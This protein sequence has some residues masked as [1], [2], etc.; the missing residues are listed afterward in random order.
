MIIQTQTLTTAFESLSFYLKE[1]VLYNQYQKNFGQAL[2]KYQESEHFESHIQEFLSAYPQ[3]QSEILLLKKAAIAFI[4]NQGRYYQSR[5]RKDTPLQKQLIETFNQSGYPEKMKIGFETILDN[6]E[7][8]D[9]DFSG[10]SS[11]E[12]QESF[13]ITKVLLNDL[14]CTH[15]T[16]PEL[17]PFGNFEEFNSWFDQLPIDDHY[18]NVMSDIQLTIEDKAKPRYAGENVYKAS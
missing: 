12:I 5:P 8:S 7:W 10:M 16:L 6:M 11:Q 13:G 4:F 15:R 17:P 2:S 18:Q 3:F 1:E 9:P 14:V